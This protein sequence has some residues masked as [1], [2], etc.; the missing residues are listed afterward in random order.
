M[1]DDD[2]LCFVS[3]FMKKNYLCEISF[4]LLFFNSCVCTQ[5]PFAKSVI[6]TH[7]NPPPPGHFGSR[8]QFR[9]RTSILNDF[10][11]G[12]PSLVLF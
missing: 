2:R 4:P 10:C 5:F 3:A 8:V 11:S 9:V 12:F 6:G 1:L 7:S